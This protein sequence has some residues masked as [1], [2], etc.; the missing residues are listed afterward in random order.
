[1]PTQT[2]TI[3]IELCYISD[4]KKFPDPRKFTVMQLGIF[5]TQQIIKT[6]FLTFSVNGTSFQLASIIWKLD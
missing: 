3:R 5:L 1:M 4:S 2:M 6:L